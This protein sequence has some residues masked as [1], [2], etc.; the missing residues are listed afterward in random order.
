[1]VP[2]WQHHLLLQALRIVP[3][4]MLLRPRHSPPRV[5]LGEPSSWAIPPKKKRFCKKKTH[6]NLLW[7]LLKF[8]VICASYINVCMLWGIEIEG[9]RLFGYEST[10]KVRTQKVLNPYFGEN[11]TGCT[12]WLFFLFHLTLGRVF[13]LKRMLWPAVIGF[14][15]PRQKGHRDQ[16]HPWL[17]TGVIDTSEM[18]TQAFWAYR[19]CG[20]CS[21]RF[22]SCC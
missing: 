13:P 4:A 19:W 21:P 16:A 11:A 10:Q 22:M 1:M 17:G 2:C 12:W 18:W 5:R 7:F 3:Q 9:I 8:A 6:G 20:C 14:H 15:P